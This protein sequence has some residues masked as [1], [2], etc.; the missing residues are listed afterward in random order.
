MWI[1]SNHLLMIL[2]KHIHLSR[3]KRNNERQTTPGHFRGQHRPPQRSGRLP[4][5]RPLRLL[6]RLKG[7]LGLKGPRDLDQGP[8]V[9]RPPLRRAPN[10][11]RRHWPHNHDPSTWQ[12][13]A[14]SCGAHR[15][16]PEHSGSIVCSAAAQPTPWLGLLALCCEFARGVHAAN[17]LRCGW[18]ELGTC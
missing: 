18:L 10:R 3:S 1:W 6:A 4:L 9:P 13:D 15:Q 8:R 12:H 11:P 5:P 2:I 17:E 14:A 7:R 16:N